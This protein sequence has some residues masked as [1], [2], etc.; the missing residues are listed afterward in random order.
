MSYIRPDDETTILVLP[1][2]GIGP[3]IVAATVEILRAADR[4]FGLGIRYETAAVGFDALK[5]SGTTF[6]DAVL[7]RAR[8]ADGIILGPVSHNDYP[9]T[10]KGGLNPSGELRKHLEL[11]ANIRPARTRPGLQV[12][13]G[14]EFD[15]VIVRENTEGFYADRS[16][17]LGPGEFMPTPD[18]ALA[19]RKITRAGSNSDRRNSVCARRT[20]PPPG[21]GRSQ[22]QCVAGIGWIIS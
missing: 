15:L 20:A 6:P 17:H 10:E 11:F 22:G 4:L 7:Q 8:A 18:I 2:D 5:A 1:G 12:R 3:E 9:P 14:Y 13:G 21:N 16:M 19:V